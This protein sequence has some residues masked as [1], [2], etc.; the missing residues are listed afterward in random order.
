MYINLFDKNDPKNLRSI[1][2]DLKDFQNHID[3]TLSIYK[4]INSI[5]YVIIR[6]HSKIEKCFNQYNSYITAS[7]NIIYGEGYSLDSL[8]TL[9]KFRLPF[10]E[11]Y[12]FLLITNGLT[13]ILDILVDNEIKPIP[14][15]RSDK[16]NTYIDMMIGEACHS[17]QLKILDWC[18]SNKLPMSSC[19]GFPIIYSVDWASEYGHV[20]VLEWWKNSGLKLLYSEYAIHMASARGHIN[21]LEWWKHSGLQ[22]KY[23]SSALYEILECDYY[24]CYEVKKKLLDWWVNSGL[25]VK[26]DEEVLLMLCYGGFFDI[27]DILLQSK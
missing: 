19:N 18:M 2:I 16:A 10:S 17:C 15:L 20:E 24:G 12:F 6:N 14:A 9:K 5:R 1:L 26:Y 25:E 22:L 7:S 3:K 13:N 23:N 11:Q 21:V 4:N 27:I 8:D